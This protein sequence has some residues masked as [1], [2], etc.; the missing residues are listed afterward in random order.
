MEFD[1]RFSEERPKINIWMALTREEAF[2][3]LEALAEPDHPLR[4]KIA[5]DPRAL[6]DRLPVQ[7]E[8]ARLPETIELP[9]PEF[10]RD[11]LDRIRNSDATESS[12]AAGY[13]FLMSVLPIG[14]PH[15]D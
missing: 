1:E 12:V 6:L 11:V 15:G 13:A 4:A 14:C 9:P 5:T 10:F 8:P 7:I 3:L 2:A